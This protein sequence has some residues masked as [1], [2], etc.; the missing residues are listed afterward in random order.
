MRSKYFYIF[1][2]C[3][4]FSQF[5]HAQD[6]HF[7]QFYASPLSLNPASTGD[8]KGD[9]RI[10]NS[11][12]NQWSS[13]T[14]KP[15]NTNA[16]GY[17][18]Q[19][20]LNSE[21]LSFGFLFISDKSGP[22]G[23]SAT[24]L[25]LSAAYHKTINFNSLHAGVQL[26]YVRKTI[27]YTGITFPNQFNMETGGFDSKLPSGESG[28]GEQISYAD[29]NLGVGWNRK[30][31]KFHPFLGLS[32]FHLT[33]PQESFFDDKDVLPIRYSIHTGARVPI[34]GKWSL[35]PS[36]LITRHAKASEFLLGSN[37][38]YALEPNAIKAKGIFAGVF[39]RYGFQDKPDAGIVV[40][41][42]NFKSLDVG[43]SYDINIS[44][45]HY[46]SH[47]KGAFEVSVIYTGMNSRLEK[48]KIPCDR[49]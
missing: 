5:S 8:Y 23:L 48:T 45:L 43:I 41:G 35:L 42:M 1:L 13:V 38:S 11:F 12:R 32:F 18:R 24:K 14:N 10:M 46:A 34:N 26:G 21:Q 36:A 3:L 37:V 15:Y 30:F 44:N 39:T 6:I 31:R 19:F 17:D 20:Y 22:A 40:A 2:F 27:S 9:W 4:G 47:Y 33:K 29:V 28:I 49:Y 25:L 16:L 7:S